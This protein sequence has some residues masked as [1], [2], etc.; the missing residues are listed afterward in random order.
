MNSEYD[1]IE[2]IKDATSPYQVVQAGME[3]LKEFDFEEIKL[4]QTWKLA[5]GKK[6][7][8]N[9]FDTSL[10]AFTI[11]AS[12]KENHTF[13]IAAAHTDHPCLHIKPKAELAQKKYMRVNCEIYGGPILNTWLDRP[14]SIAGC[15]TLRGKEVMQPKKEYICMKRPLLTIPNLAIHMNKEVNKGIELNRQTDMIPLMGIMENQLNEND[16]FIEFLAEELNIDKNDILDFD[17]YVYNTEPG[18]FIGLK[19][20]MIQSPRLDN[21]TSCFAL[22]KGL[23]TGTRTSGINVIALFDHEEIGSTTKQGA[24]S[25]LLG[26][27]LEKISNALDI[28]R[29]EYQNALLKSFLLSV[30][31]AHAMHPSRTEKSDPQ[32]YALMNDG[33]VIKISGNQRYTMDTQAIGVVIQL[34]EKYGVPYK[35]YVNHSDIAGGGTLGPMI[36][37]ILPMKTVDIGVPL[38][39]MHS[40]NE[41]MGRNDQLALEKLMTGYYSEE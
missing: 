30:D 11:G 27:C 20:D 2:F 17:L 16:Y 32:N 41:L 33:V 35:K 23:T 6:Y 37:S 36:S 5:A 13:R 12:F 39:A 22:L 21:L 15:V 9:C 29:I 7:V 40:S 28:D 31:V 10:I 25:S 34:C 4:D 1:L 3:Y 24:N 26:I 8:V 14:L 38:L 18:Q 19:Q